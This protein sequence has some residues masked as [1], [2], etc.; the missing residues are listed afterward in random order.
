MRCS[1]IRILKIIDGFVTNSSSVGTTI[2]VA[3]IK[4]KDL[5]EMLEKIGLSSEFSSRFEDEYGFNE[6]TLNGWVKDD[7][8]DSNIYD[9]Q[10]DYEILQAIIITYGFGGEIEDVDY[11]DFRRRFYDDIQL[12]SLPLNLIGKDFILLHSIED[13]FEYEHELKED[14][15]NRIWLLIEQLKNPGIKIE[16]RQPKT[17][18]VRNSL[19]QNQKEVIE[20]LENIIETRFPVVEKINIGTIEDYLALDEK[21]RFSRGNLLPEIEGFMIEAQDI[22]ALGF[23][24]KMNN[25]EPKVL[26]DSITKLNHLK[27]LDLDYYNWTATPKIFGNPKSIEILKLPSYC[28]F[29][30]P[31]ESLGKMTS[32]KRLSIRDCKG[33]ILPESIGN[34]KE[35]EV[36][37]LSNNNSRRIFFNERGKV[38]TVIPE[39]IGHLKSLIILDLSY[40]NIETIPDSIGDLSALSYLNLSGNYVSKIPRNIGNLNELLELHIDGNQLVFLPDSF[41]D[42]KSLKKCSLRGNKLTSLPITFG[43]LNSLE[44][45]DLS[46][47]SLTDLPNSIGKLKSLKKLVLTNNNLQFLPETLGNLRYLEDLWID[48]AQMDTFQKDPESLK[49]INELKR[50][51]VYMQVDLSDNKV[52]GLEGGFPS[53]E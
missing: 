32:L 15:K 28:K 22:V 5:G 49:V 20:N 35:L 46:S 2:V 33:I 39:T 10:E 4:G 42:L 29:E 41:G 24:F 38:P 21:D 31:P 48:S 36:L 7:F 12:I 3:L 13:H 6:D 37:L 16:P 18:T 23:S 40:N 9:L 51:E 30:T 27:I 34:L 17:Y 19:D 50:K 53:K 11:S 44:I 52:E 45:C 47:N 25:Q 43:D 14:I 26:P 8:L 1:I